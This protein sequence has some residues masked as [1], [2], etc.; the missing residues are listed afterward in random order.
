MNVGDLK[1]KVA[2]IFSLGINRCL[3]IRSN[4]ALGLKKFLLGFNTY[5]MTIGLQCMWRIIVCTQI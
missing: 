1:L 5:N 2:R 4:M 3:L